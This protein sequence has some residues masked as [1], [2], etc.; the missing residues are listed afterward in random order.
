MI[1]YKHSAFILVRA[2]SKVIS[3]KKLS[4]ATEH[5]KLLKE[6]KNKSLLLYYAKTI[7]RNGKEHAQQ[8][9]ILDVDSV[10]KS[11]PAVTRIK[12]DPESEHDFEELEQ[13]VPPKS[14]TRSGIFCPYCEKQIKSTSGRTLHVKKYHPDKLAEY[15]TNK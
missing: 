1:D 2:P 11:G 13:V 15:N 8:P 14:R 5:E 6:A 10:P 4:S 3:T 9:W 7:K 12:I